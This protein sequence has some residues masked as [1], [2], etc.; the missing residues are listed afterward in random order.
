MTYSAAQ[1]W[2]PADGEDLCTKN[3]PDTPPQQPGPNRQRARTYT[4]CSLPQCFQLQRSA[5]RPPLGS[6]QLRGRRGRCALGPA[7]AACSAAPS[8]CSGAAAPHAPP[9]NMDVRAGAALGSGRAAALRLVVACTRR[10]AHRPRVGRSGRAMMGAEPAR[11]R[12][13]GACGQRPPA[14]PLRHTCGGAGLLR[15]P[16]S[17]RAWPEAERPGARAAHA[18]RARRARAGARGGRRAAAPRAAA[19]GGRRRDVREQRG[20]QRQ[21]HLGRARRHGRPEAQLPARGRAARALPMFTSL[22]RAVRRHACAPGPACAAPVSEAKTIM[23]TQTAW[24]RA[25]E[26]GMP[27]R[28]W[29]RT[30]ARSRASA[31]GARPRAEHARA[32]AAARCRCSLEQH[33][34]H[35]AAPGTRERAGAAALAR[36]PRRQPSR[37]R[38][39]H[40]IAGS[41]PPARACGPEA[42]ALPGSCDRRGPCERRRSALRGAPCINRP[43]CCDALT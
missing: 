27:R 35:R 33:G 11:S 43:G 28:I 23:H 29:A 17:C 31:S 36:R 2:A 18:G 12:A 10:H 30:R 38:A 7:S 9:G 32:L 34:A 19:S 8:A 21:L 6:A 41:P 16:A 4:R 1:L 39:A 15:G 40:G 13:A 14:R 26:P 5:V 20:H 22:S 42:G 3:D 24:L 37:P 25:L